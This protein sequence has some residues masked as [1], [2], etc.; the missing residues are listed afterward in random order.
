MADHGHEI[1]TLNDVHFAY[2]TEAVLRDITLNVK[3]GEVIGII[4]PNG[5]GKS[6][7]LKILAAL[8]EP[9]RGN[10]RLCGKPIKEWKRKE[11]AKR[12]GFVPQGIE[13][14]F[15]FT[16]SE[17]VAMG[18]FPYLQGLNALDA[19]GAEKV[20]QALQLMDLKGLEH[21]LF[22]SL[23]GGEKQRVL[24]ASV[25]AQ[26]TNVFLL[27]EPTSALDLKHQI[28]IL[29]LFRHLSRS[30]QKAV[31]LV[32][33]EVNLASQFCDRLILLHKGKIV[34]DGPPDEVL[35][36]NLIR[37][38]YGVDVYIDINPFTDSIYILPFDLKNG[39][40]HRLG[41]NTTPNDA[42]SFSD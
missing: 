9:T 8:Y 6:T 29:K 14:S 28:T 12:I 26:D 38:V 5:V 27:D 30:Q 15:A 11:I 36:F 18:R 10:Y 40:D 34:K 35:Q 17:V 16:V 4:G 39:A 22:P 3:A 41:R 13:L 24:I 19:Q 25:L 32:T 31:V 2:R 7:L 37:E 21:R 33:H 23:S 42:A 1:I 20:E